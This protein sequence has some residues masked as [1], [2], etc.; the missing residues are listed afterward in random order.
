MAIQ[1]TP[2]QEHRLHTVVESGAYGSID[3]A[4]NAALKVVETGVDLGFEGSE[5][6]LNQLLAEG[7]SSGELTEEEFWRSVD[8]ETDAMLVAHQP[9]KFATTWSR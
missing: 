1:L 4:I 9:R 8:Q 5:D 7:M 2:E 6:E 3:E